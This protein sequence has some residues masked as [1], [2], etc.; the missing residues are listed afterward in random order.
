MSYLKANRQLLSAQKRTLYF[1]EK[2]NAKDFVQKTK[3]Y[4]SSDGTTIT[5]NKNEIK[6]STIAKECI[7]ATGACI[8]NSIIYGNCVIQEN[9][10]LTNCMVYCNTR[11]PKKCQLKDCIIGP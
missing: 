4:I 6:G 7:V 2:E 11:I 5:A 1:K 9:A 8:V 10:K 3:S